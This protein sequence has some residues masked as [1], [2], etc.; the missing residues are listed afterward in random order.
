MT[1][2]NNGELE[3][4][5]SVTA[6]VEL[7]D[8]AWQLSRHVDNDNLL[9]LLLRVDEFVADLDFTVALRDALNVAIEK[10]EE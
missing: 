2:N 9:A 5:F 1:N 4:S 6:D 3:G 7:D 10:E 8:L